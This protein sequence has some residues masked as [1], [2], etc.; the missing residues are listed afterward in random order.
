MLRL[1][2]E[3]T[4]ELLPLPSGRGTQS[5]RELLLPAVGAR[6]AESG[7]MLRNKGSSGKGG[8]SA[9]NS[10]DMSVEDRSGYHIVL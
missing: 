5:A 8:S 6:N 3:V 7:Q 4:R 10:A 9:R 1:A 2:G